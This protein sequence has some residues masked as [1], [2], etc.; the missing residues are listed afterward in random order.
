MAGRDRSYVTLGEKTEWPYED[1]R[2]KW[3]T[4]SHTLHRTFLA[5]TVSLSLLDKWL[6]DP[7]HRSEWDR[8]M[9]AYL[10]LRFEGIKGATS[11]DINRRRGILQY[12]FGVLGVP[13]EPHVVVMLGA[14]AKDDEHKAKVQMLKRNLVTIRGNDGEDRVGVA[15]PEAGH[16]DGHANCLQLLE[17]HLPQYRSA[18]SACSGDHALVANLFCDK[19]QASGR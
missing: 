16:A 17:T 3:C 19:G 15:V 1:G 8:W 4:D 13:M 11:E 14:F 9:L 5:E 10:S 18:I 2:G 6:E 7:E 12:A